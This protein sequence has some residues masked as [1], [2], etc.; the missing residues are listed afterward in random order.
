ML[1]KYYSR[2]CTFYMSFFIIYNKKIIYFNKELV[3]SDKIFTE[4]VSFLLLAD[5]KGIDP[6]RAE[7]L[8]YAYRNKLLYQSNYSSELEKELA[9]VKGYE[10]IE[11]KE[12]IQH[13]LLVK[14]CNDYFNRN[15]CNNKYSQ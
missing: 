11:K 4:R 2:I 13:P 10:Y 15:K 1:I 8:S 9:F 3:E 6:K 5:K 14:P 12:A 7:T